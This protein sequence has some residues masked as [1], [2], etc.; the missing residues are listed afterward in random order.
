MKS[1]FAVSIFI[2]ALCAP[3]TLS[4]QSKED[5]ENAYREAATL[6]ISGKYAESLEKHIWF[7]REAKGT[8]HE[9]VSLSFMLSEWISLA[10]LYPKALEELTRIQSTYEKNLKS[11]AP[12]YSD[13]NHFE[14]IN[15]KIGEPDRTVKLFVHLDKNSPEFAKRVYSAARET[16]LSEKSPLYRKY[17]GDPSVELD[18]L[19]NTRERYLKGV[20]K[21]PEEK[22]KRIKYANES[23]VES[24]KKLLEFSAALF[25]DEKVHELKEQASA[26][27]KSE[28]PADSP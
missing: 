17:G 23:Y 11:D 18:R 25:G 14:A 12:T 22:E 20:Y 24:V 1:N 9:R 2:F 5:F 21:S 15:R 7:H 8:S 16:L 6:L 3:V 13:F 10:Q 19:I 28:T 26:A 27:Y 4:A